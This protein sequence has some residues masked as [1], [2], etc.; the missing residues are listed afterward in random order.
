MAG[1]YALLG[2]AP[3]LLEIAQASG[4]T[5]QQREQRSMAQADAQLRREQLGFENTQSIERNKLAQDERSAA[6]AKAAEEKAKAA[7][8]RRAGQLRTAAQY[9]DANPGNMPRVVAGLVESGVQVPQ[10][11]DPQQTS[12]WLQM[13]AAPALGAP[14]I[15]KE[16]QVPYDPA[17]QRV[18][19]KYNK[20]R[21]DE[22]FSPL[23]EKELASIAREQATGQ[24]K[25]VSGDLRK[26][27]Q[28][29]QVYKDTQQISTSYERAKRAGNTGAGDVSLLFAYMKLLDPGSRVTEGETASAKDAANVPNKILQ[30][31]N[32][33]VAGRI[34]PPSARTEIF[35]E[36]EG[37]FETQ[38]AR[39]NATANEYKKLAE[40][41]G[42]DPKDVIL[43]VFGG[44]GNKAKLDELKSIADE[45]KQ[46]NPALPPEDLKAAAIEEYQSRHGGQ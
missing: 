17:S 24:G 28:N 20:R 9:I 34:L 12:Q 10:G 42:V 4:M 8:I 21:G 27:F 7:E 36:V 46:Q 44:G 40:R 19:G 41:S 45:I 30:A 32:N 37:L 35:G 43:N 29:Q 14:D 1:Y 5:R 25:D 3:S 13:Q 18:F 15:T 31:Y 11:M 33:A 16:Q 22:G 38:M 6:V 26:E 2:R 23:Y 39:Y